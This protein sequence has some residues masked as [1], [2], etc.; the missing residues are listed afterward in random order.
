[1]P[2]VPFPITSFSTS[3][4][5]PLALGY[6]I[7][8]LSNDALAPSGQ[9]C[10]G[11]DVRIPLDSSGNIPAGT[12]IW[13]IAALNPATGNYLVRAFAASGQ[14]VLGPTPMSV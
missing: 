10:A 11:R 13:S 3:N 8:E 7:V 1:M 9:I 14:L 6:L 4:G 2:M 12:T 5:T